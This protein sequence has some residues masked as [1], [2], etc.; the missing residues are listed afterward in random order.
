MNT[1]HPITAGIRYQ[2]LIERIQNAPPIRGMHCLELVQVITNSSHYFDQSMSKLENIIGTELFNQIE[3]LENKLPDSQI[4]K[5]IYEN[6]VTINEMEAWIKQNEIAHKSYEEKISLLEQW[7]N[8]QKTNISKPTPEIIQAFEKK[9]SN[10]HQWELT[11]VDGTHVIRL[12]NDGE[13]NTTKAGHCY[14]HRSNFNVRPPLINYLPL[15]F[16]VQSGKFSYVVLQTE[17]LAIKLREEMQNMI[18]K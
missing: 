8:Q 5:K 14:G 11:K 6:N 3:Q 15:I 12:Y 4:H 2:S 10:N 9:I 7:I 16:P 18:S 13:I 1:P 17:K